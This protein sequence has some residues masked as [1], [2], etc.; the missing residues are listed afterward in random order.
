MKEGHISILTGNS[1]G[2]FQNQPMALVKVK[3]QTAQGPYA[4]YIPGESLY[5]VANYLQL[6]PG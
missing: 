2:Q 3:N 4:S 1:P 6:L 5:P